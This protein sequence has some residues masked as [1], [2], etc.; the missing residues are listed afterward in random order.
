M[1]V[2]VLQG[3]QKNNMKLIFK[4]SMCL[5]FLSGCVNTKQVQDNGMV[6]LSEDGDY[7]RPIKTQSGYYYN[8]PSGKKLVYIKK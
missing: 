3:P 6:K 5:L 8:N 2:Q 7:I 1:W 4:V